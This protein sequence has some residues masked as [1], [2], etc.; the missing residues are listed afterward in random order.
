MAYL[1]LNLITLWS[2]KLLGMFT[3]AQFNSMRWSKQGKLKL[4]KSHFYSSLAKY[5]HR[6]VIWK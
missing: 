5:R 4:S 3:E 1:L 2:A 6:T